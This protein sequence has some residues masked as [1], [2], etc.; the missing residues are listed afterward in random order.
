MDE[1]CW[2]CF[3][4]CGHL[5]TIGK[6]SFGYLQPDSR[7]FMFSHSCILG[8]IF[9][10]SLGYLRTE[11]VMYLRS[12]VPAFRGISCPLWCPVLGL[13]NILDP[14]ILSV[15]IPHIPPILCFSTPLSR[16]IPCIVRSR[17]S[18]VEVE[19]QIHMTVYLI[20][21]PC[22]LAT[23]PRPCPALPLNKQD[24]AWRRVTLT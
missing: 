3:F 2:V 23:H 9:N 22:G 6:V 20:S 16:R 5:L 11:F 13:Y 21:H 4:I 14:L 18:M 8:G 19:L 10:L 7:A 15:R 12:S 17:F 24:T 1:C